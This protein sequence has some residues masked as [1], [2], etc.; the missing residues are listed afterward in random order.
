MRD[1][2]SLYIQH[3][4]NW[5]GKGYISDILVWRQSR[6]IWNE[7][8]LEVA[9]NFLTT[10]RKCPIKSKFAMPA[11]G[12]NSRQSQYICIGRY[13]YIGYHRYECICLTDRRQLGRYECD[14][15]TYPYTATM[16]MT[17]QIVRSVPTALLTTHIGSLEHLQSLFYSLSSGFLQ[18][19]RLI[20]MKSRPWA[21][22]V[23]MYRKIP[24]DLLEGTRRGSVLSYLSLCLMVVL[25]L[26][27]TS[28]FFSIR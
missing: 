10:R 28:A 19:R 25:F 7:G 26:Y 22:H 20:R 3:T 8:V 17:R 11:I 9:P 15:E 2:K 27:E 6:R 12:E 23:D 4:L 16:T 13:L 18:H 1:A 5:S 21:A 24:T 14:Y